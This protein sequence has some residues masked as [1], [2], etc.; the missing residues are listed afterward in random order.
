MA[1]IFK[2]KKSANNVE[3]IV[4][5]RTFRSSAGAIIYAWT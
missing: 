2:A 1:V 3:N 4:Y 5:L